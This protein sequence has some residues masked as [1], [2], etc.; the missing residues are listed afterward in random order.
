MT[1]SPTPIMTIRGM[2]G[3]GQYVTLFPTRGTV[4][5]GTGGNVS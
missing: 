3:A 4:F 5:F 2:Q 1:P